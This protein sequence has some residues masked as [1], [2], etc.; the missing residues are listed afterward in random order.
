MIWEAVLPLSK[1]SNCRTYCLY[2]EWGIKVTDCYTPCP[3][4]GH[5]HH[6]LLILQILEDTG[7]AGRWFC[8]QVKP[9]GTEYTACGN[10]ILAIISLGIN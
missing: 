5:A 3:I 4:S 6:I 10:P 1:T 9:L 2:C 8:R 7:H